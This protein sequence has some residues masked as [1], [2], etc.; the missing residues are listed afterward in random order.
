LAPARPNHLFAPEHTTVCDVTFEV[1]C[2]RASDVNRGLLRSLLGELLQSTGRHRWPREVARRAL[3]RSRHWEA[4]GKSDGCIAL[5]PRLRIMFE[6][7]EGIL[8]HRYTAGNPST[9]RRRT[10]LD[11]PGRRSPPTISCASECCHDV[12]GGAPSV[13][14]EMPLREDSQQAITIRSCSPLDRRHL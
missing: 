7:P 12:R 2:K 5:D 1:E 10:T 3:R 9:R 6:F 4:C 11:H 13:S 14:L 8:R